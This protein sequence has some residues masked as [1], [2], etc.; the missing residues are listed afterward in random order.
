MVTSSSCESKRY[1]K[2]GGL[3]KNYESK[4]KPRSGSG[5][6]KIDLEAR[7]DEITQT[8]TKTAEDHREREEAIQKLIA[9]LD[10][11]K[12]A[13]AKTFEYISQQVIG[14][15]QMH[16]SQE[17]KAYELYLKQKKED[18][19]A[20]FEKLLK[21]LAEKVAPARQEYEAVVAQIMELQK[22]LDERNII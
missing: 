5:Y 8:R 11:E 7:M 16:V 22:P 15:Y 2:T 21:E 1:A 18:A 4:P 3:N 20:A 13:A 19:A 10:R 6:S 14:I 9:E 12:A 17:D